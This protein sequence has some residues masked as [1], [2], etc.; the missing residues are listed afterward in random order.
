[1]AARVARARP[2]RSVTARRARRCSP[3]CC[4]RSPP[5]RPRR[6]R[7]SPAPSCASS[8]RA[9][10]TT[11]RRSS[12]CERVDRVDGRPADVAG[13]PRGRR[14]A[15]SCARGCD[16]ARRRRRARRR[17]GGGARATRARSSSERR[18]RGTR[19]RGA[20]PRPAA[21]DRPPRPTRSAT[22]SRAPTAPIPGAARAIVWAILLAVVG[23]LA[24]LI[25]GRTVRRRAAMARRRRPRRR[26]PRR[27]AGRA[28]APRRRGRAPRRPRGRAAPAL[29]RRPAAARRPRRDRAPPLAARPARS[30]RPLRSD[31]FDRLAADFDDVVYG[32]PPGRAPTTSRPPAATGTGSWRR[33]DDPLRR[34]E[35]VAVDRSRE[36]ADA[37]AAGRRA[38]VDAA[39][40]RGRVA[41]GWPPRSRC[42]P[43]RSWRSTGSRRRRAGPTSSAY[44]TAPEGLAA[45]ADLLRGAGHRVERRRRP[46]ADAPLD[47]GA[48]RSSCST[49]ASCRPRRRGRSAR[50]VRGGG[51][52]IAGGVTGRAVARGRRSAARPRAATATARDRAAAR[53]GAR[54]RGRRRGARTRRTAALG[55]ARRRAAGARRPADAPLAVVARSGRGRAVLLAERRA[56]AEPR[57]RARRQRRVRRSRSPAPRRPPGHVPGDRPRL[58][59]RDR[60]RAR[61]PRAS[62]G[63]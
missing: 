58:R 11:P 22:S 25:A 55:G 34:R 63:R 14:R 48:A 40:A 60:P 59:R 17:P 50:F 62:A 15:R 5:R 46:L 24:W 56:A 3:S 35:R 4:S 51:R 27:V 21:P 10:P 41:A 28:R 45:Y 19:R 37:G 47:R 6:P 44:A 2:R 23:G 33:R 61:C 43:R 20:V 38:G 49:R 8:P 57:A 32:A 1:M 30:S 18:F 16:A 31:D 12:G 36:A 7:R 9:R 52:L 29:P 53:A 42:S 54:D 26:R 39:D 13:E